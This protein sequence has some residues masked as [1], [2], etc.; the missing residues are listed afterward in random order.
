M[1]SQQIYDEILSLSD[2]EL[3]KI[4]PTEERE[5]CPVCQTLNLRKRKNSSSYCNICRMEITPITINYYVKNKTTNSIQAL[6]LHRKFWNKIYELQ[7]GKEY[8][9]NIKKRL[10]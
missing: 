4:L 9:Q 10:L 6:F 8:I 7:L 5:C 3:L 1:R 2:E